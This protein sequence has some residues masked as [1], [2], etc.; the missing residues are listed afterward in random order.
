MFL[1]RLSVSAR[2]LLVLAIGFTFQA[3]ISIVSL[4]DQRNSLMQDRAS[5]VRHLLETGYST[6]VY[7]HDQAAK[8]LITDAQA[9]RAAANALRAMHYDG[10]N[11]FCIWD[12]SGTGIAHGGRPELEGRT[13]VNSADAKKYP[14]V[15][16]MVSKLLAV[17]KTDQKEG[18]ISYR[19]P[20]A[21]QTIPLEKVAY[22]RV[23]EPWGWSISTGAYIDDIEDAFRSRALAA[24]SVF[25]G[26]IAVASALTFI[27]GRDLAQAMNRLSRR[28]TSVAKG[29][30]DDEVPDIERGD[31]VGVMARALMVL[32]DTSREVAELKL[33]QLTGLP[34]RKLLMD[35]L[36]RAKALSA[37]SGN[38]GALM[39]IDMDK[40][41]VLND[42]H[43]HDLGDMLL[44]EVA[45]R[46]KSSLREGD[47]VARLGG[48]EFVLV[49]VDIGHREPEAAAAAEAVGKK[50][51][52]LLSQPYPLGNLTH[53]SAASIGITLFKGDE[54]SAD[55]LLKQADLAMYKSKD[56]GR[57]VCRFFGP[58]ME[59]SK[60]QR[61]ALDK[62]LRQALA[63]EQFQ[64]HYQPQVGPEGE[65]T[66]AE[67]LVRWEHPERG[68]V[69]PGEFVAVAEETG[70]ILP[71]GRWVLENVCRQ[72]AVWATR[73]ET[74]A[75]RIAVNVSARQFQQAEFVE[76]VISTLRSTGADPHRL[77]LE[78]T[79]SLLVH[80]VEDVV[81]K[82]S[83]LKKEG[84]NFALDDFGTGYSSLYYLKRL[85][86][87]QLK[88]DR[89]FVRDVLTDPDDA[90][91]A[92]TIVALA[93]TLGLK[94]I[95]EGIETA[96][97]R[98]FLASSGCHCYQGNFFSKPLPSQSFEQFVIH[99]SQFRPSPSTLPIG[100]LEAEPVG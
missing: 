37:R 96:E 97:Q 38:Y 78:L 39:L 5:E 25:I 43:G 17:A 98:A 22:T 60:L 63:D 46:L 47:T 31:E 66:G 83:R 68:L 11:Y 42:T 2:F 24:L 45:R 50:L 32:R 48:D 20:K 35:Q 80:N 33:D 6:V 79:E 23:F 71:L 74:A 51:L 12:L 7:Y 57:N 75:L 14:I 89:S 15:A 76:Q 30:L 84:V 28:I 44:R 55:D 62:E 9:R 19:I 16:S 81:E 69:S 29:E 40:F 13:F 56:S 77:T 94:V 64:L 59:T 8:G 54:V 26:L 99:R 88:I 70:L 67:A 87:D 85:P 21:G 58:Q 3:G 27:I 34:T 92:K 10:K 4:L 72:L 49:V 100:D 82:M 52:D 95:A 41:K 18:A 73:P 90:A 36:K 65:L 1:T 61:A 86:L 53:A 93:H 91:I